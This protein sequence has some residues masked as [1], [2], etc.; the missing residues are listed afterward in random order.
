MKVRALI[1]ARMSSSR[2]PGKVLAPLKGLPLI[3]HVIERVERVM[4]PGSIVLLTSTHTSDDPLVLYVK[5]LKIN[6]FRGSLNNVF[7][8]FHDYLKEHKCDHFFRVC[9]DSPCLDEH[10]FQKA[11]NNIVQDA[12]I[13]L[14]TN[15][16]P[17]TY[18]PG[19]SVELVRAAVF[20]EVVLDNMHSNEK[21]HVTQYFYNRSNKYKIL[22]LQRD[23]EPFELGS[24]AVDT[25]ADL[26]RLEALMD[27]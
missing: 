10:L 16:F 2:Y 7:K 15:K 23:Q 17:P 5:S 25:V 9:A 13:D 24:Y 6:V 8:R 19:K 22:N 3:R 21:E 4:E 26:K 14:V 18:P 1:Q 11:L 27:E 20:R 12:S